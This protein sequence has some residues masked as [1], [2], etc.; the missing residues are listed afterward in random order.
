MGL[1][2]NSILGASKIAGSVSSLLFFISPD[3]GVEVGSIF[4]TDSGVAAGWVVCTAVAAEFVFVLGVVV[5][6][7]VA[8]ESWVAICGIFL[9]GSAIATRSTEAAESG[10]ETG[11]M[12]EMAASLHLSQCSSQTM[13]VVKFE[14]PNS[15]C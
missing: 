15:G 5:C 14:S 7:T 1:P 11:S 4:A 3:S 10:V 8:A 9:A 2:L 13:Q 12:L 6:T